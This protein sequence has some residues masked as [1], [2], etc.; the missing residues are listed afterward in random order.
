M[1]SLG[2]YAPKGSLRKFLEYINSNPSRP[3]NSF[4]IVS[5][6]RIVGKDAK[7][8]TLTQIIE[9]IRTDNPKLRNFVFPLM[10]QVLADENQQSNL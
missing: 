9:D 4:A 1:F 5:F 10:Q 8:R 3:T 6:N 2:G 7:R